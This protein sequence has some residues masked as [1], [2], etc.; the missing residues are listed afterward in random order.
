[1]NIAN[2]G[3]IENWRYMLKSIKENQTTLNN[4]NRENNNKLQSYDLSATHRLG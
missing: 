1:M 3:K 4:N 2:K